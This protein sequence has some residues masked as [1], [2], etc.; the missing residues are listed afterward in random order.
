MKS[1][2]IGIDGGGNGSRFSIWDDNAQL[3]I[4]DGLTGEALQCSIMPPDEIVKRINRAIEPFAA[5][6]SV[7]SINAGLAGAAGSGTAET[8]ALKLRDRWRCQVNVFSDAEAA[9]FAAFG[10][11]VDGILLING[12]GSVMISGG[13]HLRVFGGYG[14]ESNEELS[15]RTLGRLVL[16]H[17]SEVIDG[18]SKAD[19]F[20]GDAYK[21]TGI[22]DRNSLAEFYRDRNNEAAGLAPILLHHAANGNATANQFLEKEANRFREKLINVIRVNPGIQRFA[23]H[24]GLYGHPYFSST[25]KGLIQDIV[26]N[27]VFVEPIPPVCK[28]LT[29]LPENEAIRRF[30]AG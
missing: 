22:T 16:Q 10:P 30:G 7:L 20:S 5:S 26:L 8:I 13:Q 19:P 12:T 27:A 17:L 28:A 9:F 1:L 3:W 4:E 14:P 29:T 18:L 21:K 11:D 23:L 25:V 24:G 6:N 15:G 2:R